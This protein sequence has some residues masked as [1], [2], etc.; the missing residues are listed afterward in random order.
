MILVLGRRSGVQGH[1][2]LHR[3]LEP[4]TSSLRPEQKEKQD[5]NQAGALEFGL[6]MVLTLSNTAS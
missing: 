4:S 2:H 5:Y 6:S 3:R 1:P